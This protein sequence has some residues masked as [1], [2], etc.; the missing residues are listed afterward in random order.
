M[1]V[2]SPST[3]H[4]LTKQG[5]CR[6]RD[7]CRYVTDSISQIRFHCYVH[8]PSLAE[9]PTDPGLKSGL[10]M[11]ELIPILKRKEKKNSAGGE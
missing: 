4:G 9:P 1:N 2:G 10:S 7:I 3:P 6:Q 5:H 11:R 8:I